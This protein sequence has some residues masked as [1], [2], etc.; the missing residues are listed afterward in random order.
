LSNFVDGLKVLF[1]EL[2]CEKSYINNQ[3]II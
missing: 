2:I 3:R 1:T